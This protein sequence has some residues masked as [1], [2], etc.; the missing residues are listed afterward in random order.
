MI[1]RREAQGLAR[2][3]F[4]GFRLRVCAGL[5]FPPPPREARARAER[6]WPRSGMCPARETVA[7]A[8]WPAS[9]V[10][11]IGGDRVP[12]PTGHLLGPSRDGRDSACTDRPRS[13]PHAHL[14]TKRAL[15]AEDSMLGLLLRGASGGRSG[16][17]SGWPALR[18]TLG[19][20]PGS[21]FPPWRRSTEIYCTNAAQNLR[22]RDPCLLMLGIPRQQTT[23]RS[24]GGVPGW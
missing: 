9:G 6:R 17:T 21:F 8:A 1:Q 23:F 4:R 11:D 22:A 20:Y 18:D 13:S 24:E 2:S 12:C 15:C 16:R 19:G 10:R 5:S 7:Y 14:P 3:R